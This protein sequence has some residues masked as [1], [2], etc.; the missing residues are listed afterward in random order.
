MWLIGGFF[1][2]LQNL[3]EIN[4]DAIFDH[5]LPIFHSKKNIQLS[6]ACQLHWSDTSTHTSSTPGSQ[7]GEY[8]S[9][10][11]LCALQTQAAPELHSTKSS[12]QLSIPCLMKNIN[13]V[14]EALQQFYWCQHEFGRSCPSGWLATAVDCWPATTGSVTGFAKLGTRGNVGILGHQIPLGTTLSSGVEAPQPA[15]PSVTSA[16]CVL[17]D[18]WGG[19]SDERRRTL[20]HSPA[21][22][23][24]QKSPWKI[25]SGYHSHNI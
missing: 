21:S 16:S 24:T 9:S 15:S 4:T 11:P 22:F 5:R 1:F 8:C 20:L 23:C 6:W 13:E 3:W 19:R 10:Q 12:A 14:F 2:S 17:M 18:E 7:Q 25:L